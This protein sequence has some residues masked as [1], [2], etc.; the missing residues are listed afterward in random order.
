MP[1]N[2]ALLQSDL[3]WENIAA[4][5]AMFEEKITQ[6]TNSVDLIVLP[7][8][9]TTGFTMNAAGLA[10]PMNLS[11]YKWMQQQAKK[12]EAVVVWKLYYQGAK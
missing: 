8:M 5:L 3:F 7:E 1:L 6:I 12:T 2:L 11:T 10:E 4:N 9:F